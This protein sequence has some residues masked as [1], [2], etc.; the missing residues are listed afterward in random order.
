MKSDLDALMQNRNLDALLVVGNAE[1]NPPMY[2]LTGGG[3]VSHATV[4]KKRGEEAAY[5]HNDMERDEAAKSGLRLIPYSKYDYDALYKEADGDL[6]LASALR[7]RMMFEELGLTRGRVG[8]YGFYDLSAV[9]GTLSRLQ[10]LL[11]ELEFVGEPRE[12]SIFMRAME[13][14]DAAE[15]ERIRR[16]GRITT[17]VVGKTRDYLTEREVRA[18]EVLLKEDGSPLTVGDV[19]AKIRLWVAEQGA[20]L[21]SG[22]IFAI[23]RDAG[24]PHST[25]NPADLMRLG[26]TIVFDIY[27]AE[28]GGG[29]Y[30]DFTRTWSLGYAAPEAQELYNQVKE[31][32]DKLMDNFDVNAPFKHYH[33]MT[34]EYF[35]SKGHQSPLNTKAPVEGYVHSLGHGVGLNIHERPFS[36]LTSS[37]DQRLAPGVVITSEPGLYYPEKGMGFRIEDTLWVRPDGTIE[38]LADYPYDFVLPMKKRK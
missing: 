31:I 38:T 29:Y 36:S 12:D 10:K 8:V 1:H 28:A 22:F 30:Y 5:F 14:K 23:G 32:F 27:P 24:V 15:V 35:E 9:F 7:Y 2:Y 33:K 20:E 19:H 16:M 4:I 6:L 18:D 21:P 26:Q 17:T 11:P 13:T 25:G 34:C 37:D 3:H